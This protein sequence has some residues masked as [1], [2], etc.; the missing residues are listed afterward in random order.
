MIT[1][2]EIYK[3]IKWSSF[4]ELPKGGQSVGLMARGVTLEHEELN[5]KISVDFTRSQV[6]NSKL[7]LKIFDCYIYEI[8]DKISLT[9]PNVVGD[10]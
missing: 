7:A 8:A 10:K 4:P 6:E 5:I 3:G 9:T 1:K 2:E